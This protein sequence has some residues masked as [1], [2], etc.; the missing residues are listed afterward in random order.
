MRSAWIW[1]CLLVIG[2]PG[3]ATAHDDTAG[4]QQ[5]GAHVH[6]AAELML[7]TE[8]TLL[9]IMLQSPVVNLLG[10]EHKPGTDAEQQA[11]QQQQ[12]LLQRGQWLTLPSSAQC[13]LQQAQLNEPWAGATTHADINLSLSYR[14]DAPEHLHTVQLSLFTQAAELEQV[15]VQWVSGSQQGA[16][17]LSA[18][19]PVLTLPGSK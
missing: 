16:G 12:N 14:C 8:G 13:Q 1:T 9:E 10:F 11:W 4:H 18:K 5:H 15:A 3:A 19:Q 7:A 6:G 2:I 17:T